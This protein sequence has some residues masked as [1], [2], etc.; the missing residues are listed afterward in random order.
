MNS[1]VLTRTCLEIP[2]RNTVLRADDSRALADQRL[3]KRRQRR[4]SM[5]LDAQVNYVESAGAGKIANQVRMNFEI[6]CRR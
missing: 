2:P 1:G 5:R 6:A 3:Q 4:E